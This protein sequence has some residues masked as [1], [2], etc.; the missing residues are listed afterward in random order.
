MAGV[1]M[2]LAIAGIFAQPGLWLPMVLRLLPPVIAAYA[3]WG[4]LSALLRWLPRATVEGAASG[5]IA[6]LALA[7]IPFWALDTAAYPGRLERHHAALAAAD[8][9]AR[10]AGAQQEA[11]LRAQFAGLGP[12]SSLRDYIAAR[13]WYLG[14]VDILAGA[15]QVK[16]R[17]SDAVAMLDAGMIVDLSD[18]WQLDLA[19]TPALC[20]R[21]GAALATAFGGAE[22]GRGSAFLSLLEA[23]VPNMQ[24]LHEGDCD[25]DRP[26]GAVD[27]RLR[28]MLE[29]KDPSGAAANDPAAYYA[30]WGVDRAAVEA[31]RA[32]L[33][34][35]RAPR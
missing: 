16:S 15:R 13:H 19:P 3:L 30:R 8:A 25:L 29:S 32:M 9:A 33:S 34:A 10:E 24:W 18:L 31:M 23:Q 6:A 20:A 22:I 12:D 11:A 1:A 27:A 35:F 26:V 2:L 14:G 5:A 4:C 17:Q 21:Y 7:V 28:W